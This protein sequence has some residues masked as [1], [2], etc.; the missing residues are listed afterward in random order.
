M[1]LPL[2]IFKLHTKSKMQ[3]TALTPLWD[4]KALADYLQVSRRTMETMIAR[5]DAPPHLRI[6]R[7]RRWRQEDVQSWVDACATAKRS[8]LHMFDA[9]QL[10]DDSAKESA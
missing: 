5:G 4:A 2:G 10:L 8:A 9:E 6:G 7:Q 3:Q 1:T